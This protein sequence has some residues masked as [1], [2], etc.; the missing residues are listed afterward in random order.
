MENTADIDFAIELQ[1]LRETTW[2][3]KVAVAERINGLEQTQMFQ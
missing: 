1:T 2:I 3:D